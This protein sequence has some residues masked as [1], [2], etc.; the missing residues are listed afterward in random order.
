MFVCSIC[1]K[2]P[3]SHSFDFIGEQGNINY[4]YSCP[5]S[6]L[7]YDDYDGI[8]KHIDETLETK[9]GEPWHFILDCS[10]FGFI[11]L[12]QVR[13]S[14]AIVKL[15]NN[16]YA[17]HLECV[18]IQHSNYFIT[19]LLEVLLPFLSEEIKKRIVRL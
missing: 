6:S 13:L 9:R 11:H 5:G 10:G 1:E 7:K 14:I 15:V 19:Q 8:V 2:D 3:S 16:K 17:E 12:L 4:F 18:Y